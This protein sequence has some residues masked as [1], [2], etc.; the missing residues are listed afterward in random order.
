MGP[1]MR[2]LVQ[3]VRDLSFENPRAPDS[4]RIDG[5]PSTWRSR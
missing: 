4:L 5:P 1:Q 2:V 3:Y